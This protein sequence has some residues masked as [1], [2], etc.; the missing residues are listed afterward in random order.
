MRT[1]LLG[2][3]T[4]VYGITACAF[5]TSSLKKNRPM[6]RLAEYTVFSALVMMFF[7]A[8]LP[9]S[10]LPSS[11]NDT[12]LACVCSP[13]SFG[14]TVGTPSMMADTHEYEVP[15]SMPTAISAMA[16]KI[17]VFKV[18]VSPAVGGV[19]FSAPG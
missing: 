9:T 14:M 17:A 2:P 1:E 7:F 18:H 11:R 10:T 13:H 8:A 5:F 4:M 19:A 6:S 15:R 12:Q 16:R 3:S